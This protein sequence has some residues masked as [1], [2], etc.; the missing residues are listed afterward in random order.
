MPVMELT[1]YLTAAKTVLD[2]FKGIRAELPQTTKTHEVAQHIEKAEEALRATE[3]QLAKAL[4]YPLCQCTWPPQIMLW[5]ENESAHLC[6]RTECG[7]RIE[8]PRPINTHR[9]SSWV[10]ARRR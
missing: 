9:R 1:A 8:R 2:L 10:D 7:K 5:H 4:G 6:P 3:A